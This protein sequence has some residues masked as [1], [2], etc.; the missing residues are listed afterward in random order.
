M[1]INNINI[2]TENSYVTGANK[3][4]P[5]KISKETID[6][7]EKID[8]SIKVDS[9]IDTERLS[10]LDKLSEQIKNKSFIVSSD[11]IAERMVQDKGIINLLLS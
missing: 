9:G 10:K 6:F 5:K 11:A 2:N 8:T 3:V 1:A 7:S 4:T